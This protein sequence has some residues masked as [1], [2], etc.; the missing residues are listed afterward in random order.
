[1]R[2]ILELCSEMLDYFFELGF[3]DPEVG[4]EFL[5][6]FFELGGQ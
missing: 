4:V 2:T 3:G 6:L 1:M 5:E